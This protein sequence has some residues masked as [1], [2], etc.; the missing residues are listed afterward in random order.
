[1]LLPGAVI[2][3]GTPADVGVFR[4]PPEFQ[5]D[6][7]VVEVEIGS[8]GVLRNHCVAWRYSREAWSSSVYRVDSAKKRRFVAA[9]EAAGCDVEFMSVDGVGDLQLADGAVISRS[10]LERYPQLA[11]KA[12][13]PPESPLAS[14]SEGVIA[15]ELGIAETGS[16]LVVENELRDRLVS[17]MSENLTVLIPADAIEGQLGAA[18][19]WLSNAEPVPAYAVLLT[20]PS[21]TADIERSLTIGVQGPSTTRVIILGERP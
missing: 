6:G 7:G 19:A 20:G 9:A 13:R 5:A 4:D 8:L 11:P 10:A 12:I 16:V 3:F 14:F 18:T 21:R 2:R 15:G 17:M 1:M